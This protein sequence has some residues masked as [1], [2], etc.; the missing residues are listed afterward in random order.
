M[1]PTQTVKD[2]GYSGRDRL[3]RILLDP[4]NP[5]R[6]QPLRAFPFQ[7]YRLSPPESASTAP[8]PFPGLHPASAQHRIT[9]P[10]LPKGSERNLVK[11]PLRPAR[12]VSLS[13]ES[14]AFPDALALKVAV[15][16]RPA[17]PGTP[18]ALASPARAHQLTPVIAPDASCLSRLQNPL[19]PRLAIT[20][21]HRRNC[22]YPNLLHPL[23]PLPARK[24]L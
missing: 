18:E 2:P 21:C 8:S 17:H 7:R 22:Q 12:R 5:F 10:L 4:D 20:P 19:R 3:P 24:L 6:F 14:S 9:H 16:D 13:P 15:P 23:Q 11:N 1:L